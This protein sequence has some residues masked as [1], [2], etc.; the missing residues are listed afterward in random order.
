M[1]LVAALRSFGAPALVGDMLLT[2]HG[3]QSGARSKLV[4]VADNVAVAW[5][6][7]L[8]AAEQVVR[9]L[10]ATLPTSGV[11]FGQV[12]RVLGDVASAADLGRLEVTLVGWVVDTSGE[13][14]F[15]WNSRSALVVRSEPMFD[16]SGADEAHSLIGDLGLRKAEGSGPT[17]MD[18]YKALLYVLSRL[19]LPE[20]IRHPHARRSGH[21][22]FYEA[23]VLGPD[24]VFHHLEDVLF[25]AL[26]V[27]FDA[28]GKCT[29]Q[30]AASD[31]FKYE[32]L[33][34]HA[35]LHIGGLP[36]TKKTVEWHCVTTLG[37]PLDI[38]MPTPA[39]YKF[40]LASKYYCVLT[41]L[42]DSAGAIEPVPLIVGSGDKSPIGV[43]GG[44][45]SLPGPR[46]F[47]TVYASFREAKS[48]DAASG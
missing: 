31:L 26:R 9:V 2:S 8:L 7:H 46:W 29:S 11:T 3:R 36:V 43:D 17:G 28:S 23:L 37:S 48:R 27:D 14:C 22:F 41:L 15:K 4:K 34:G 19:M 44:S 40:P 12:E 45:L 5:T 10:L 24:G 1:T 39:G 30:Q 21:G 13:H 42:A 18:T 6:G 32:R 38:Q 47:E 20:V 33:G 35:V 16:G 25:V